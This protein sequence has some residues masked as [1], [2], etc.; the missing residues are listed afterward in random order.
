MTQL[1]GAVR[2]GGSRG[3]VWPPGGLASILGPTLCT[4]PDLEVLPSLCPVGSEGDWACLSS[5]CASPVQA[6]GLGSLFHS[7]HLRALGGPASVG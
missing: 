3:S 4:I 6:G 1:P 7:T 2:R 5:I